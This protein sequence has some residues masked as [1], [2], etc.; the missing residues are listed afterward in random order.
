[1][2]QVTMTCHINPPAKFGDDMSSGFCFRVLTYTHTH[3]HT[4]TEPLNALLTPSTVRVSN[5]YGRK[6]KASLLLVGAAEIVAPLLIRPLY[7]YY[8]RLP[9]LGFSRPYILGVAKFI[10]ILEV[11]KEKGIAAVGLREKKDGKKK[12]KWGFKADVKT[13]NF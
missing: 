3:T 5:Y 8:H 6:L 7:S 12:G 2:K 1:M 10:E 11:D 9:L 13:P 4:R